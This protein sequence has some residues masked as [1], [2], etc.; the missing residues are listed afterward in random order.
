MIYNELWPISVLDLSS[1]TL[2]WSTALHWESRVLPIWKIG[3]PWA[4]CMSSP[5]PRWWP[6]ETPCL[7][8]P[9]PRNPAAHRS[10][11][12]TQRDLSW[13]AIHSR[14]KLTHSRPHLHA[15]RPNT[16]TEIISRFVFQQIQ[17][18][19]ALSSQHKGRLWSLRGVAKTCCDQRIGFQMWECPVISTE[20]LILRKQ[21]KHISNFSIEQRQVRGLRWVRG[22][23]KKIQMQI[24]VN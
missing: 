19:V 2:Q 20:G 18:L 14:A 23:L 10:H 15:S 13:P 16:F 24:K 1:P 9:D 21:T 7:R 22:A 5:T 4:H 11:P 8:A 3:A 12:S 6:L 17:L